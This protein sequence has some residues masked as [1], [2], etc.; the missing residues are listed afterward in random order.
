MS[1][2]CVASDPEHIG[3]TDLEGQWS[4]V[5]EYSGA[6]CVTQGQTTQPG[7]GGPQIVRVLVLFEL[8]MIVILSM[9]T[10]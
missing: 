2:C 7:N 9:N 10:I 1:Y 3:V 5:T 8:V 6:K 4:V